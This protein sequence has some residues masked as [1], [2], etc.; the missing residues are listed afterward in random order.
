MTGWLVNDQLSTIPG[1]TTFWHH[2][3]DAIPG[4]VD[5]TTGSYWGLPE[6]IEAEAATS[7]P[8]YIIRNGAFFRALNVPCPV[9]SLVQDV[10]E[11]FQSEHLRP[12]LL[13]TV[14]ASRYAVF[15]TEYTRAQYPELATAPYRIIPIGTDESIFTPK[16]P[17]PDIPE[18]AVLWVGSGHRIKGFE[19]ARRLALESPRP[20]VFVMKDDAEVPEAAVV[21]R[22]ID[23]HRLSRVASA[24][25]VAVCTSLQETQHLAG[26]EAGMCG[27]PL[28][29]T[30]VGV[31]YGREKGWWGKVVERDWHLDI[32]VV[33]VSLRSR[34]AEYWRKEGFGLARCMDSWR[35]LVNDL[36][37]EH[38]GR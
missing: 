18:G 30:N 38:V 21:L 35:G 27:V 11:M 19:L 36:E 20:W 31:Y 1:T 6:A 24:C 4:L 33:S 10:M 25:S 2:L 9:V 29:T 28:V 3:L 7:P 23:H 22:S 13:E 16:E 17:D 14:S 34:V 26:I 15:N 37:V 32:E 5:K 8:D 12:R